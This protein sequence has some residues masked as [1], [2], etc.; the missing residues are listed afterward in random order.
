MKKLYEEQAFSE[1]EGQLKIRD[2]NLKKLQK[3][4]AKKLSELRHSYLQNEVYRFGL[5][6]KALKN[7]NY[8]PLYTAPIEN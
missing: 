6:I 4:Q 8:I 3:K 2:T 1:L 5:Y 7:F